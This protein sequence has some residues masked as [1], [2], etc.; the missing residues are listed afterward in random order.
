M[1]S[2]RFQFGAPSRG[3]GSGLP[4]D[5]KAGGHTNQHENTDLRDRIKEETFSEINRPRERHLQAG[6]IASKLCK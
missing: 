2:D 1:Q 6:S 4:V 3:K 5:F